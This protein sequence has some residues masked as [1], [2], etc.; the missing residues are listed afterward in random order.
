MSFLARS[1]SSLL[2]RNSCKKYVAAQLLLPCN[3]TYTTHAQLPEEHRMVYDMCRK[4]AN[5]ELAPNAG[6]WDKK[7]EFPVQAIAHLVRTF[8]I[9][10]VCVVCTFHV[11]SVDVHMQ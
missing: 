9:L 10:C 2:L 3:R 5:E 11:L 1:S 7:H 6:A 4:F 8:I